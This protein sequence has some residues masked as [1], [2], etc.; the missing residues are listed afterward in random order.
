MLLFTAFGIRL[1]A[2]QLGLNVAHNLLEPH[3]VP[4]LLLDA[5]SWKVDGSSASRDP[6]ANVFLYLAPLP[7]RRL[8]GAIGCGGN[9]DDQSS[10]LA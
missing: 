10:A 5:F 1:F 2:E 6:D 7:N 4:C 3:G 9:R 8:D